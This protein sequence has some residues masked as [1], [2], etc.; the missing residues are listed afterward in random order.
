M[1]GPWRYGA[2]L[3]VQS[4]GVAMLLASVMPRYQ[5]FLRDSSELTKES[6]HLAAS[7]GWILLVQLGYWS[8][9]SL[10]PPAPRLGHPVPGQL[11]RFTGRVVFMFVTSLFSFLFITR[12]HR[13]ELPG[14]FSVVAVLGLFSLYC[15]TD[16]LERLGRAISNGRE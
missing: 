2:W 10:P 5:A 15:Y 3:L 11:V 16:L 9:R 12:T 6:W 14:G 7:L 8:S 4:I 1:R 13:V